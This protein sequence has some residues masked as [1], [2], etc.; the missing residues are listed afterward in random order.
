M[1]ARGISSH[2]LEVIVAMFGEIAPS[3]PSLP[4]LPNTVM[5][6]PTSGPGAAPGVYRALV[7]ADLS[8]ATVA[9][10]NTIYAGPTSGADATASFRTQ[11]FN[12]LPVTT[13][14][15][16]VNVALWCGALY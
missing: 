2:T 11:V 10:A 5:A 16:D 13:A 14:R 8:T 3:I 7:F 6:G 9:P 1:T 4:G 12:D 15:I